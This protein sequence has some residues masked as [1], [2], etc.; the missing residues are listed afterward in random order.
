MHRVVHGLGRPV[1][2][3]GLG[4]VEILLFSMGWLGTILFDDYT[5]YTVVRVA[6]QLVK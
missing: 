6:V 1:G 2:W 3:V 4:W 5:T